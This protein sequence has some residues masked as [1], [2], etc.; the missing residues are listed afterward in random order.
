MSEDDLVL[1]LVE[2][3][4]A[5]AGMLLLLLL[6]LLFVGLVSWQPE[7]ILKRSFFMSS[8]TMLKY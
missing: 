4:L 2:L 5:L 6:A 1:R 8:N 7:V 3:C